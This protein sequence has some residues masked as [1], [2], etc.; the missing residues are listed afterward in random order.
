M[1]EK[2]IKEEFWKEFAYS[3]DLQKIADHFLTLRREELEGLRAEIE[4]AH[5]SLLKPNG[6]DKTIYDT[7]KAQWHNQGLDKALSLINSLL[8]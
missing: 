7:N 2:Q 5:I 4:K 8:P 6:K 1:T 3:T